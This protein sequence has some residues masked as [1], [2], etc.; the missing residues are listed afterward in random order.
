MA[1]SRSTQ[2]FIPF[3][4][5]EAKIQSKPILS[6]ILIEINPQ[7]NMVKVMIHLLI[8]GA[9]NRLQYIYMSER[10]REREKEK[11]RD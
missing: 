2:P 10:E 8:T 1:L 7:I 3:T 11:S 5:R 6:D 4:E 9:K